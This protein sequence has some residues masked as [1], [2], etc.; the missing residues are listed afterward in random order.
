MNTFAK[1]NKMKKLIVDRVLIN[2]ITILISGSGLLVVITKFNVPELNLNYLGQNPFV[3]KQDVIGNTMTWIF[4]SLASLGFIIQV[5]KEIFGERIQ[6]RLHTIKF[7]SLFFVFGMI[8]MI[9]VISGLTRAGNFI[10]KKIWL[11]KV[12][13]SQREVFKSSL[14]IVE[15]NGWRNDQLNIKEKLE[16]K[17]RYRRINL[18]TTNERISQVEKLLELPKASNDLKDRIETIKPYFK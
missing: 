6:E 16:D 3:I 11:P 5:L 10:A 8:I 18:E 14:D 13:E 17:E 9:F 12:V 4:T 2:L 7:Y 15:N 1:E